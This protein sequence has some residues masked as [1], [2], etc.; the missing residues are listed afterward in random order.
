VLF[1]TIVLVGGL[2]SSYGD[3]AGRA[4]FSSGAVAASGLWFATLAVASYA[5]GRYVTGPGVWRAV[6]LVFGVV[7]I[8]LAAKLTATVMTLADGLLS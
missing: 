4:V 2:A 3:L 1:D 8:A 5:A 6:D 7:M